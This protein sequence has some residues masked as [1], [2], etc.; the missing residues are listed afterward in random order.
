MATMTKHAADRQRQRAIPPLVIDWLE[1]F[2]A[3]EHQACAELLYFDRRALKRLSSYTGGLSDQFEVLRNAYLVR[4]TN[5]HIM[6]VG[7]R[8]RRINRK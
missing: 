6:T 2:G 3:V 4:G 1:Q 5:G 7:Y 8:T